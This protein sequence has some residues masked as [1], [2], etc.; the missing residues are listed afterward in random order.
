MKEIFQDVQTLGHFLALRAVY[1]M[2]LFTNVKELAMLK[3][4]DAYVAIKAMRPL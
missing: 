3:L 4:K 1:A 2:E